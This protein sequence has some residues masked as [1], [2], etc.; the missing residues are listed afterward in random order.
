M[1]TYENVIEI[2]ANTLSRASL[3][4]PFG[5]YLSDAQ[6]AYIYGK[7]REVVEMD[8][9]MAKDIANKRLTDSFI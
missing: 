1:R 5:F 8:I 4:G 6:I 7:D 9:Q 3:G 2:V